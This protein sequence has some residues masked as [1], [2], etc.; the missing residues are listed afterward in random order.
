MASGIFTLKQ[1]LQGLIQ[2]AWA[3]TSPSNAPKNVEYLVVAGGG[4]AAGT[5]EGSGFAT[6]GGG[7]AGGL[8]Q[9][10]LPI[11]LGS[12]YT[13]T[14]GTGG[15]G[16]AAG[17]HGTSGVASVFGT[18]TAAGGGGGGG[19]S[20]S[21]G[22]SGGGAGGGDNLTVGT[23]TNPPGQAVAGQ[24]NRGG[25]GNSTGDEG[26]GGGGAGTIGISGVNTY[27]TGNGGA[28][29][30]SSISGTVTT[31]AGG[32]GGGGNNADAGGVGGV[33]GGG[34]RPTGTQ[35]PGGAASA[36]SGG[37]GGGGYATSLSQAAGAGGSGIVIVRYR[38]NVQFFS[39]GTLSYD[40]VNNYTVHT[41]YSSGTL[42]PLATPVTYGTTSSLTKS[43]R[44]RASNSAYLNRTFSA[45]N[46]Q[47]F[48]YSVWFKRSAL[49]ALQEL[50]SAGSSGSSYCQLRLNSADTLQ[51]SSEN[52]SLVLELITTQVFRDTS[53]WYHLVVSVDTTQATSSDRVKFYLNGTQITSFSSST[54][55]AQNTNLIFNSNVAHYIGR[56]SYSSVYYYDGYMA[57]VNLIDGQTLTPQAFGQYDTT[58]GVWQPMTFVGTYGTNGFYLPFTN[59][60]STTTLGY[61][62]SGNSNNWTT[63]NISLTAGSTYDSMNDVPTLTSATASNYA[64]LNPL[65]S[66]SAGVSNGNLKFSDSSGTGYQTA[67]SISTPD[68]SVYNFY[69]EVTV[70]S[71]YGVGIVSTSSFTGGTTTAN[72][73]RLAYY[74]NG[75]KFTASTGSSYGATFTSGDVIGIAIGGGNITFY[76]NGTSQ[77]VAFSSLTGSYKFYAWSAGSAG[78]GT[79]W[80]FGQQPFTYTPPSG[81]V[82]LNTYNLPTPAIVRSNQYM[83]ATIYTGTGSPT[84]S[85][86]NAGNFQPDF[87]WIKRRDSSISHALFNSIVGGGSNKGLASDSAT[88]EASFNDNSTYGYLNSFD[89]AGFSVFAGNGGTS[90]TNYNAATY[91]GWQ[92]QA[93]KGTNSTNTNGTI[94]STVSAST[95]AGFSVVTYTGTGS[96]A[97]VGHGLGAVPQMMIIK[98]RVTA[99]HWRVYQVTMG[100]V[101]TIL[102]SSDAAQRS[103]LNPWNSTTPTSTVFTVSTDAGVNESGSTFVAYC[104]APIAG[105]SAF[106]SYAGN[107]S[108]SGP[109]VYTGFRPKFV[110]IKN[111]T[112]TNS[113][114]IRDTSRSPYNVTEQPLWANESTAE[115]GGSPYDMYLLSNGFKL[116]NTTYETNGS[117][118]NYIYMAFAENPF[119]NALAR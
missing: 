68:I 22:G 4:G 40:S 59:T 7:G 13:V 37:G 88:N 116:A 2:G 58:S 100:N 21:N 109:F 52:T 11:V 60:T 3:G 36:N 74:S 39:G 83:D 72:T 77:G 86:N 93:G 90:Y 78:N 62:S 97:T 19:G 41:F 113:W 119:R 98:N 23:K 112:S 33:G 12:S 105:F 94:T 89:S 73:T 103:D 27:F 50:L 65:D 25:T 64:V 71:G 16:G 17:V 96:N 75:Q 108:T 104:F 101:N 44:F 102:L 47:K 10:L 115:S 57:E 106:G 26:S 45:G 63:N 99:T 24:G 8:L 31:Y 48:T 15:P 76:K 38:G 111:I 14:I 114:V 42:A 117:A 6:S 54:Y 46:Q 81:F 49:G 30:A 1:Q 35:A 51:L 32:G 43:L 91:V 53:A 20:A 79:Q 55:P 18:I 70:D 95:T 92:W 82:A 107:G 85:I 28:G 118:T 29:I 87:V 84:R 61:D 69:C 67:S 110:M 56:I 80:N 9:G 5:G 34:S 66:Y